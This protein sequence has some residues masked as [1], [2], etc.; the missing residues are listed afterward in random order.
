MSARFSWNIRNISADQRGV[1]AG[2]LIHAARV[3]VTGRTASPGIFDVLE[4]TGRNR[5]LAR[6]DAALSEG[7]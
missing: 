2:V 4:L 7:T 6:I 5:V 3:A 1:K